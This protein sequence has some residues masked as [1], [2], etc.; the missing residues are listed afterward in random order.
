MAREGEDIV[1]TFDNGKEKVSVLT[2]YERLYKKAAR[3]AVLLACKAR[4][5][6]RD[7]FRISDSELLSS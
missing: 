5:A 1:I 4:F 3:K 6:I 7:D 2:A